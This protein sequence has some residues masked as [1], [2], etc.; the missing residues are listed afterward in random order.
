MIRADSAVITHSWIPDS[1]IIAVKPVMLFAHT[2]T[3]DTAK[4]V[5][6]ASD[7]YLNKKAITSHVK[8]HISP[9]IQSIASNVA[10]PVATPLPPLNFSHGGK[11]CPRTA[12]SP[13]IAARS[14]FAIRPMISTASPPFSAS[15][16][17]VATASPFRPVLSTFVAPIFPEPIWRR[18]ISENRWVSTSPRAQNQSESWNKI[19]DCYKIKDHQTSVPVYGDNWHR[20]IA[21]TGFC[22]RLTS[23]N[24]PSFVPSNGVIR[25]WDLKSADFRT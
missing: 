12:A 11:Q 9:T 10:M 24:L 22:R 20:V 13:Q 25:D 6:A 21:E 3:A 5:R 8:M 15:A 7:E 19:Q 18:L 4:P 23:C 2:S 17:K 16:S 1:C 14:A